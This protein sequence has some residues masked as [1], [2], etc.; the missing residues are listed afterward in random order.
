MTGMAETTKN[1]LFEQMGGRSAIEAVTFVFYERMYNDPWLKQFF[2]GIPREHIESQQNDF[3]QTALGGPKRYSGKTPPSAHQH[4]FITQDIYDAREAHLK[5]A[6]SEC[7]TSELMVE[8]WLKV[9]TSFH[10]RIVK[11]SKD[12]CIMRYSSEGIR[13]FPKP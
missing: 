3:M 12:D 11:K 7:H 8:Q 13:D 6:F 9:D 4:I 1:A 10:G 2:D 5:V